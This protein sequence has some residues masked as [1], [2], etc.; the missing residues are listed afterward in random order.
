MQSLKSLQASINLSTHKEYQN[1]RKQR[2][3]FSEN[4]E[5]EEITHT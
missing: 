1:Y 2:M 3:E 4:I 5:S